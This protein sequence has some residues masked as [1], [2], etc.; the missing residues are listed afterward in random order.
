MG[1]ICNVMAADAIMHGLY[2]DLIRAV[3]RQG[4]LQIQSC[5]STGHFTDPE[6]SFDRA[7]YRSRALQLK[8]L[9]RWVRRR[10]RVG[11]RFRA[12][13]G[14]RIGVSQFRVNC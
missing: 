6:L 7:L 10:L 11:V 1:Y 8:M 5:H 14:V 2:T 3:I 9:F 12:R 4:T 13:Y